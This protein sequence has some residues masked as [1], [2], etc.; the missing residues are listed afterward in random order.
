MSKSSIA[1]KNV[2]DIIKKIEVSDQCFIKINL[3]IVELDDPETKERLMT[4]IEGEI[5]K[6]FI[7]FKMSLSTD[8]YAE[9]LKSEV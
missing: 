7:T 3:Q 8:D 4:W 6:Q 2:E 5:Q 1:L 9:I